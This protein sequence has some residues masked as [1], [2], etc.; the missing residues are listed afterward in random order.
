M[1]VAATCSVRRR[2]RLK[3]LGSQIDIPVFNIAGQRPS[4]FAAAADEAKKTG[5][6]V[7]IY[8]AG[9]LAR[10]SAHGGARPDQSRNLA[11]QH[12]AGRRFHDRPGCGEDRQGVPRAPHDY[13]RA[14]QLDGVRATAL[15]SP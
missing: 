7:I 6:D 2:R 1:L 8:P 9:R 4:P 13:R 15:R 5:R 12:L 11:R 10:R 14:D 3:V